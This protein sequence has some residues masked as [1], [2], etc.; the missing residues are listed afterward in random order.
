MSRV[1]SASRVPGSVLRYVHTYNR[2]GGTAHAPVV[3]LF[4]SASVARGAMLTVDAGCGCG[5]GR[6][7]GCRAGPGAL[8]CARAAAGSMARLRVALGPDT[9]RVHSRVLA[10]ANSHRFST[11]PRRF[12]HQL[13]VPNGDAT[14]GSA[15]AASRSLAGAIAPSLGSARVHHRTYDPALTMD[16]CAVVHAARAPR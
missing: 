11:P 5:V 13:T 1:A 9:M 15:S 12:T 6:G 16:A 7:Y 8:R 4:R 10:R 2:L 14:A 3:C